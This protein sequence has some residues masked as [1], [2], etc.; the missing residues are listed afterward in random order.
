MLD[1]STKRAHWQAPCLFFVLSAKRAPA[2]QLG[3]IE[4]IANEQAIFS[5]VDSLAT[6]FVFRIANYATK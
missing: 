1:V 6:G 5:H 2:L 3:L 4:F